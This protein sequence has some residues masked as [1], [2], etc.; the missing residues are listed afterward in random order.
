MVQVIIACKGLVL[1]HR[2]QA[3]LVRSERIFRER[4]TTVSTHIWTLKVYL[5]L[6]CA[7]PAI[8]A[9]RASDKVSL[10]LRVRILPPA[11]QVTTATSGRKAQMRSALIR[12]ARIC[13]AYVQ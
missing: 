9:E 7:N 4:V 5:I 12:R 11:M 1:P 6:T 13:M 10:H 2:S 3:R 8:A